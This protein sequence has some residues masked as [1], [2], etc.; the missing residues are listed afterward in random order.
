MTSKMFVLQALALALG[1]WVQSENAT[2]RCNVLKL[3][4]CCSKSSSC[5]SSTT[6]AFR[7]RSLGPGVRLL[8]KQSCRS[9]VRWSRATKSWSKTGVEAPGMQL[10]DDQLIE[11]RSCESWGR[12][13]RRMEYTPQQT[14]QSLVA[15]TMSKAK[16]PARRS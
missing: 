16:L 3:L 2:Q 13:Q 8:R 12:R 1:L 14:N 10:V 5:K 7:W 11:L 15:E 9:E 6:E 4:A